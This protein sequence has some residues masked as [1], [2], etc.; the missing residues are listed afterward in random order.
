MRTRHLL[1]V[2]IAISVT[3]AAIPSRAVIYTYQGASSRDN[4]LLG[5][6]GADLNQGGSGSIT[7]GNNAG[8]PCKSLLWF[9]L[10]SLAAGTTVNSAAL[11]LTMTANTGTDADPTISTTAHVYPIFASNA[12][13][14]EGTKTGSPWPP[15]ATAGESSWQYAQFNTVPW[16]NS[17]GTGT[18]QGLGNPGDGYSATSIGEVPVFGH[19][20]S[21][22]TYVTN[23]TQTVTL[24]AAAIQNWIDNPAQNAGLLIEANVTNVRW[25]FYS[26]ETANTAYQPMLTLDVTIPEPGLLALPGLAGLG[27]LRRRRACR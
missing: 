26:R 27:L 19:G 21:Y 8:A 2:G 9:D 20:E 10:S 4:L 23:Y 24:N 14:G 25:D 6:W 18:Y 17:V 12:G 15:T 16:K 3:F 13:W 11:R 22:E 7:V 5:P 1:A